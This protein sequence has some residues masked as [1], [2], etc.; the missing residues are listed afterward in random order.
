MTTLFERRHFFVLF[1]A[2]V[3][4]FEIIFLSSHPNNGVTVTVAGG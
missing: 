2:L 3:L 1:F 4:L